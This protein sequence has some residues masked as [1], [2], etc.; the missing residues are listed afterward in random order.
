MFG[1]A[2]STSQ[3]SAKEKVVN[4]VKEWGSPN[5]CDADSRSATHNLLG[6]R[7]G[8]TEKLMPICALTRVKCT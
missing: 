1:R 6:L 8:I 3:Q 7:I 2:K 4:G 5:D